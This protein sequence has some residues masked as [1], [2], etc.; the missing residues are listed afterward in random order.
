MAKKKKL[1]YTSLRDNKDIHS[2]YEQ[3]LETVRGEFGQH[4]PMYIGGRRVA[5]IEDFETRSPIDT[6]LVIGTF[7]KG[8]EAETR[9]AVAEA[10][11]SF[12]AWSQ[13]DWEERVRI[14]RAIAD[15]IENQIL[16]LAYLMTYE[17]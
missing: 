9:S 8:G 13:T 10:T 2:G 15:V 3:A 11:E 7:Q 5:A 17:V 1:T 16:P 14:I 12:P 4:H 6:D